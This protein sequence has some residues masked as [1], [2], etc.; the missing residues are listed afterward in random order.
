MRRLVLVS[1][2]VDVSSATTY[3]PVV[4][5]KPCFENMSAARPGWRPDV[6]YDELP[7][8]PSAHDLE[9]RW[10]LKACI[11]ARA[12]VAELKRAAELIPN[13]AMLINTIPL[14]EAKDSSAIENVVTTTDKLFQFAQGDG[15]AD[16][17]T[18]EALRYRSA[19]RVGFRS[20]T[21]RPL[22]TSIAVEICTTLKGV[23]LDVRNPR[24]GMGGLGALH[25]GRGRRDRALDQGQDRRG[26]RAFRAHPRPTSRHGCPRSTRA[27]S[28]TSSSSS[29]TAGS[30][31]WST[32]GSASARRRPATFSNWWLPVFCSRSISGATSS[33]S[34]RS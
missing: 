17:A 13:Q 21:Q 16:P 25:A 8:L 11:E 15:H 3:R 6:A 20:L 18:K 9:T 22:C 27:N 14:L 23:D 19:L 32:R 1:G 10:I 31:I 30:P 7:W 24:A 28:W 29:R 33:S 26:A 4:S 34:T 12:A 2:F 5:Q